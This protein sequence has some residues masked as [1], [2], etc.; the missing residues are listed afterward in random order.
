MS[1]PSATACKGYPDT[2]RPGPEIYVK[3]QGVSNEMAV[4]VFGEQSI[5]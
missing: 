2:D 4:R 5:V 1:L 3:D